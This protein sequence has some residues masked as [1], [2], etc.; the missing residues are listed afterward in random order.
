MIADYNP[1]GNIGSTA[2]FRKMMAL[3]GYTDRFEAFYLRRSHPV[4]T[5]APETAP[6]E[7]QP[8]SA[9]PFTVTLEYIEDITA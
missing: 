5:D 1:H 8:L 7:G 9:A 6:L 3:P 4:F 2:S